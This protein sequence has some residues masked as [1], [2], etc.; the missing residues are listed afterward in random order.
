MMIGGHKI[1]TKEERT[2][3]LWKALTLHGATLSNALKDIFKCSYS[4]LTFVMSGERTP[5]RELSERICNFVGVDSETFF[6]KPSSKLLPAKR[7]QKS[8]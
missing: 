7:K 5:S 6:G 8:S 3:E 2:A 1:F 4:H